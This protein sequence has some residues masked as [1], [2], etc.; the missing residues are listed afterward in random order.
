MRA[1]AGHRI[2]FWLG[3][4]AAAAILGTAVGWVASRSFPAGYPAGI[5]V[6]LVAATASAVA[7]TVLFARRLRRTRMSLG[8]A[9]ESWVRGDVDAR[10][11]LPTEDPLHEVTEELDRAAVTV[12]KRGDAR[13]RGAE[14]QVLQ[15]ERL[16]TTGRLAAGVAHE[17]NNPLSGILLCGE[18]LLDATAADDPRRENLRRIVDQASRARE[19][20]QG[21]LDFARENPPRIRRVDLNEIVRNVLRLLERQ[22]LYQRVRVVLELSAAPLWVEADPT[23]IE[24]VF[25]NI[26][27][28]GL[29]AMKP[30]DTLTIR[31]GFSEK[32]GYCRVAVT[33]TGCGIPPESLSRLFEPFFTTKEVGRGVGLGLA[34]SHGIVQQHRGQIE[35]QSSVG[36]GTTF[37]V[38]LPVN[39]ASGPEEA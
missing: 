21:L 34:I 4:L 5:L 6:S 18:I 7:A 17:I 28:N 9:A 20:V 19:I 3:I 14:E 36:T 13:L 23:K 11:S 29:E 37:R 25:V 8:L 22:P 2:R 27:M 24:Q 39:G 1:P 33:D 26:V 16:A 10:L 12:R 15:A 31:S 32:G 30:G 38:L 35:V